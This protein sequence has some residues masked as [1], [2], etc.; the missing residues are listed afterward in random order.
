MSGS[1]KPVTLVMGLMPYDGK[2]AMRGGENY[3]SYY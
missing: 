1:R 2:I 3:G